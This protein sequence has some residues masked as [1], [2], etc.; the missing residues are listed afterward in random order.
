MYKNVHENK[1]TYVIHNVFLTKIV[2]FLGRY[3]Q[4]PEDAK[5][6]R[7]PGI[8]TAAVS[9]PVGPPP[10][11]TKLSRRF[12]SSGVV[13]GKVAVS[14]LSEGDV[15][16]DHDRPSMNQR[17]HDPAS[18]GLCVRYGLQLKTVL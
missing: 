3:R 15:S 13:V 14:K 8:H 17:T 11:T 1:G 10:Q 2:D 7:R 9:T 5:E 16:V 18:N 12:L 6:M 4:S